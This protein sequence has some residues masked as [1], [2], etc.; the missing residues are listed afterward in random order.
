M[1]PE[2]CGG[3]YGYV[4]LLAALAYPAHPQHRELTEWVGGDFDPERFDAAVADAS[5]G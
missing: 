1:P 5:L 3:P 2:D 4:E